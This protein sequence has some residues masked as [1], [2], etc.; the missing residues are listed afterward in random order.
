METFNSQLDEISYRI[1]FELQCDARLSYSEIGRRVGL[2]APAVTERVR[3]MEE[4]GLITGYH[5]AVDP[6]KLGLPITVFIQ[7][8]SQRGN[9][10][11]I[12]EFVQACPGVMECYHVT[13]EKDVVIKAS[14]ASVRQ[15]E[16]L[17]EELTRF[18]HVTTALV[19]SQRFSQPITRSAEQ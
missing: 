15:L 3:R 6:E 5:A 2:S 13:G 9:C 12:T 16:V 10:H 18:G 11:P 17:V 8:T 14:F 7:V 19:L 4:A 1:L